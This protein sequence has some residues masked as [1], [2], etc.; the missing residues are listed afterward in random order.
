MYAHYFRTPA[1]F[2]AQS[3]AYSNVASAPFDPASTFGASDKGVI[4]DLVGTSNIAQNTAG[5]TP[6]TAAGQNIAYAKDLGPMAR[7]AT[8][9]TAANQFIYRGA[10]R[11]LGSEVVTNG[12][13]VDAST[14]VAGTGWSISGGVATKTAG[15]ASTLSQTISF[16]P[17]YY[18]LI[19]MLTRTAGTLT[20]QFTGGSTVA[21][22]ARTTAGSYIEILLAV[23]GNTTLEFSADAT[24]AGTISNVTMAPI[25][26]FSTPCAWTVGSPQQLATAAIDGSAFDK[27]T[28]AVLTEVDQV[29][30]N[31]I[32]FA[33][34]N[35]ATT[36]GSIW[37]GQETPPAG[38]LR[39]ATAS[40]KLV[41]PTS[42]TEG[43]VANSPMCFYD[44]YEFDLAGATVPDQIKIYER[45]V[46]VTGTVTGSP[47]GG[48][49]FVN[50]TVLLG[51]A[52]WKG[53]FK[54]VYMRV[55]S[56]QLTADQKA[57][58]DAWMTRGHLFAGIIGDSTLAPGS[59]AVLRPN[60]SSVSALVGGLICNRADIAT[61]G[62]KIADQVTLWT[63]LPGKSALQV[64]IVQIGLNDIKSRIGANTA[65][66][67]Q[68]L[69]DLQAFITQIRGDVSASCKIY[70]SGLTPCKL[71][72]DAATNPTAAYQA[73]LDINDAIAG[74]GASPIT[75]VDGRITSHVA[76]LNDGSGNLKTI[77][78]YNADGVHESNEA[79][80]I[81][82]MA[83]R[84]KLEADGLLS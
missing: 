26:A 21:G 27:V 3:P 55:S 48:G 7:H 43:P 34:G 74:N 51:R 50:G 12:R 19:Y 31:R 58:V 13:F 61:S 76:A 11:T 30:A 83:W 14:W 47:A 22:N 9:T 75:G 28:L 25:T 44:Y 4:F 64:V 6:V 59:S 67:A 78:D 72:L 2:T 73:W 32:Y 37:A 57:N 8:Q 49:T 77:Y 65:T 66:T 81:I 20:P 56:T 10:P 45:G 52:N 41:L 80:F 70:V 63:S 29:T 18:Q 54:R 71:W 36:N 69:S 60:A 42:N 62:H 39:G 5:T 24:F 15:T 53:L 40:P 23:S 68:V 33:Y 1:Q 82:A 17:G 46:S 79:R 38:Y 84:T 16:S 35:Y